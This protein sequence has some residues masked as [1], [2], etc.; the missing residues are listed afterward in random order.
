MD[1]IAELFAELGFKVNDKGLKAFETKL[2]SLQQ[3]VQSFTKSNAQLYSKVEKGL[4]RS[5]LAELRNLKI[6]KE[7][8][9]V[10][11]EQVK[12]STMNAKAEAM[13]AKARQQTAKAEGAVNK[14]KTGKSSG[15]D[16][17]RIEKEKFKAMMK[18]QRVREKWAKQDATAAANEAR[19]QDR[20]A[21]RAEQQRL[22][23]EQRAQRQ[24]VRDR[25][26]RSERMRSFFGRAVGRPSQMGTQLQ[27]E[28]MS[29]GRGFF[30]GLGG[31][32]AVANVVKQ[33]QEINALRNSLIAVTGSAE[34]GV[35]AFK[36]LKD[37]ARPMGLDY[38]ALGNKFAGVR[39][40]AQ[41][42]GMEV[43]D[44]NGIFE[45]FAKYGTVMGLSAEK[46]DKAFLAVQ[47][48]MSYKGSFIL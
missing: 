25:A 22:R 7:K 17:N 29:W 44:A 46:M 30:P 47:Q 27:G 13:M 34:G 36:E 9:K 31:A 45:S 10:S 38:L 15:A 6:Q 33:T 4:A 20:E 41:S 24:A 18:H 37:I 3:T 23:E 2:K 28:A 16:S 12:L 40:A 43:S 42:M 26:A 1:S 19:R 8:L 5:Q 35:K 21:R 39:S 14:A 32:F 11:E 48:M